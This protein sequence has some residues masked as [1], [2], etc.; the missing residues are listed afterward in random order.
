MIIQYYGGGVNQC[1]VL[2]G[3]WL[4]HEHIDNKMQYGSKS[5][6]RVTFFSIARWK[7]RTDLNRF[8]W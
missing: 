1:I 3:G 4:C 2:V 7:F 8:Y 5:L 6:P